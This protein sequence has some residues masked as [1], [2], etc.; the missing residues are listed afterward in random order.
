MSNL[1]TVRPETLTTLQ[2]RRDR[3]G[4]VY[5][6]KALQRI[7]EENPLVYDYIVNNLRLTQ[8][9]LGENEALAKTATD[10]IGMVCLGVYEMLAQQAEADA[11]DKEFGFD[12]PD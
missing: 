11:M 6:L 7:S 9:A 12:K 3:Q 1:P 5:A 4:N 8:R 2:E 10:R